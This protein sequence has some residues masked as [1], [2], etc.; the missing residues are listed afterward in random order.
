MKR[1]IPWMVAAC[2]S[3]FFA[4]GDEGGGDGLAGGGAA[5]AGSTAR[6]GAGASGGGTSSTG[7]GGGSIA[8]PCPSAD[9]SEPC[10]VL[11]IGD[12]ITDG[13]FIPGGYRIDLFRMANVAGKSLTFVGSQDNGPDTVDDVPFPTLHEGHSGIPIAPL[14]EEWVPSPGLERESYPHIV[15]LMIGTNDVL[16]DIE[17]EGAPERCATLI[18]KLL[19]VYPAALLVVSPIL[20]VTAEAPVFDAAVADYNAAIMSL[21]ADRAAA[22]ESIVWADLATGFPPDELDDGV[23]PSEEGFARMAAGWYAVIGRL[24]PDAP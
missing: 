4:C 10:R 16:D 24:L 3:W 21:V 19:T 18:D 11:P 8:S 1:S 22:G 17:I 20:P 2:C 5:S 7:A 6:V 13:F 9:R 14:G 23:H 15:L 12:S